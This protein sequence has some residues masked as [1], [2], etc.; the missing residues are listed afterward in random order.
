MFRAIL[1]SVAPIP[2]LTRFERYLF[3]GPHPDD[4]EVACAPT[5]CA[6]TQ[7]G[8]HVSFV[9]LTDGR[10]GAIDPNL[11]GDELVEIRKAEALASVMLTWPSGANPST[12]T[13]SRTRTG[14]P[15]LTFFGPASVVRVGSLDTVSADVVKVDGA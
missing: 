4:I 5:V 11:F 15:A 13:P 10:M 1:K 9:V 8:K 7:A 2:Q 14:A 12:T 3:L 6:L